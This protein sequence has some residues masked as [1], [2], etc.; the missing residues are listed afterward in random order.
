MDLAVYLRQE[1]EERKAQAAAP[2]TGALLFFTRTAFSRLQ[3]A[4]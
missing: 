1:I 2:V 3:P 4:R